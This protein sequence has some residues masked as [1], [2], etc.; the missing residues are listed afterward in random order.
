[1]YMSKINKLTTLAETKFL[2]LYNA[3]Y[4][5]KGGNVK[6]WII[7]S[8]KEKENLEGVYLNNKELQDDAVL[9]VPFHKEEEKI[10]VIRQF[11]VPINSYIYEMPAGLIDKGESPQTAITRELKEETGLDVIEIL[12]NT[13]KGQL[14]LSPGM[15]DESVTSVFCTCGG[16]ISKAYMEEDED[17]EPILL[18]QKEA[19]ELLI[20]DVKF[21]IK[22]YIYLQEFAKSG[23]EM[24]K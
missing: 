21:D 11:R 13:V 16:T 14:F 17:I 24:F 12:K 1:M 2:N 22:C 15:T 5:N 18:S 4:S 3:E 10:V 20:K 9:I 7:A 6:N 19:Q 8:R 23:N